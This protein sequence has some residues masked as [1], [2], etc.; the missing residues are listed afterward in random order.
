MSI[1]TLLHLGCGIE[2]DIYELSQTLDYKLNKNFIKR[3]QKII[4]GSL[5]NPNQRGLLAHGN[6]H[7]YKTI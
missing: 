4:R 1:L 7:N 5:W 3:I 6:R 2:T